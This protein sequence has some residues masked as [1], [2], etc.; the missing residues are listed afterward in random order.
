[1]LWIKRNLFLAVGGLVA[2]LL[3]AGGVY[4]FI[5]AQQRNQS[6]EEQLE[7]NKSELNRLQGQKPYPSQANVDLA[8]KENEKLRGAIHQL[9]RFFTPV[10]VDS[11]VPVDKLTVPGFR[12]FRDNTIAELQE[13]ARQAKT[14][15]P[16][17]TY[18]FSFETQKPKT[19]FK[20][21]TFP[22]IPLQMAEVRAL[23]KILFDAHVD[24]LMNIRR[25][26]VSRDDEESSAASDY[27]QLRVETNAGTGTVRS[28]YEV[29]F[30]CLSSDLALVLQGLA[31]SPHGFIVKA[32][33]VEPAAEPGGSALGTPATSP[34]GTVPAPGQTPPRP[35]PGQ[36]PSQVP[37]RPIPPPVA[38]PIAAPSTA[39]RSGAADRPILLLKERRLKVTLLIYAVK[40]IPTK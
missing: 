38:A 20:D 9:H 17:R 23:S 30:G 7:S 35:R 33:H 13:M 25:A 3:L 4:A 11:P 2:L 27:L 29:T 37:N 28:P 15:L 14:T 24:P 34:P 40:A 5:S 8:R 6:I 19:E 1:M 21:G 31:E 36:P 22:A 10:P 16:S 26:R 32:I 18:A 39:T 12:S